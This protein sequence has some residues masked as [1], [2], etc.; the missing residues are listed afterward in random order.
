MLAMHIHKGS[1][2]ISRRA[3]R[4]AA[5][6][7][8][9]PRGPGSDIKVATGPGEALVGGRVMIQYGRGGKASPAKS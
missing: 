9:T 7:A 4:G 1:F 6:A 2:T 8:G 3:G 5:A